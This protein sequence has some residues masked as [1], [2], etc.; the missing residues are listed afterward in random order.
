MARKGPRASEEKQA[1]WQAAIELQAES[2]L[3]VRQFCRQEG[4]SA[5][6]FYAWRR[7]LASRTAPPACQEDTKPA[8]VPV[9]ITA[10]EGQ[11]EPALVVQ[12]ASGTKL[13]VHAGCPPELLRTTVEALGC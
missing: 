2:G 5:P 8:F 9:E 4:L 11:A 12:L 10:S 1:Y 6:S 13:R 7:R 3:S